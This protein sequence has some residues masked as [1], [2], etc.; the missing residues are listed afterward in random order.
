MLEYII[1]GYFN[2]GGYQSGGEGNTGVPPPLYSYFY[3]GAHMIHTNYNYDIHANLLT[4]CLARI[5]SLST[6]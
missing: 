4:H 2:G 3:V 1:L 6:R 5:M